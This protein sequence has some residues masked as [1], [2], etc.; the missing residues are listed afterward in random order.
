MV[1]TGASAV[2][3]EV[4]EGATISPHVIVEHEA[5]GAETETRSGAKVLA[6]SPAG[7]IS[8][9]TDDETTTGPVAKITCGR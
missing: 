5:Y 9:T 4:S 7:T 1:Q 3:V 2:S 8:L 6:I